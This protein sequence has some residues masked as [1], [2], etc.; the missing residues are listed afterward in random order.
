[1]TSYIPE[2]EKV[3]LGLETVWGDLAAAT[4][5]LVGVQNCKISP[6]VE[7]QQIPDKC[8]STMPA[9]L[10]A[11]TRLWAEGQVEGVVCYKHFRHWL[12]A[13]FGIDAVAPYTYLAD[14]DASASLRSFL[15]VYG[16]PDVTY[17]MGGAILDK[18]AVKGDT[19]GPLTF[20]AHMLGKAA[21]PDTLEALTR[22]TV[23]IGMGSH[24]ALYIDPIAGPIGTTP[25][26]TTAFAF[27]WAPECDRKLIWH[28]GSASPDT[29][30]H[31]KWG[32]NLKLT[33][34]MT[35]AMQDILDAALGQTVS[36]GNYA[37]RIRATDALTTSILTL[38][39]AGTLLEAPILFT[40]SEGLTT[41]EMTF[42]PIYS[43]DATFLSCWGA[44]LT[45]P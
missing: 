15:L 25:I 40:D 44:A 1:M 43:S 37:V 10:A 8:G 28:L 7:A 9:Y 45:L 30:K 4:V 18:L 22:D 12:D 35:A 20:T 23:V 27:E 41:A 5:E 42:L 19:N 36:P 29:F 39:M 38:D 17:S 2:L 33:V 21:G 34:Q 3:Q 14:L 32:G 26:A 24:C 16:Q 6:K 31:G 11:V 13:M